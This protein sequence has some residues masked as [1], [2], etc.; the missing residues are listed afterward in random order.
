MKYN[1]QKLFESY[2]KKYHYYIE[3]AQRRSKLPFIES[4]W[5]TASSNQIITDSKLIK[6]DVGRN[7]VSLPDGC[8]AILRNISVT[9]FGLNKNDRIYPK[10]LWLKIVKDGVA[11][12]TLCLADHPEDE[13]S[14][15]MIV[16][17]WHNFRVLDDV[18]VADLYLTKK[19]GEGLLDVLKIDGRIGVSS[20]GYGE[21]GDDGQTVEV[22][23]YELVR[24]GDAVL[25]PSQEVF[26]TKENISDGNPVIPVQESKN[27][28]NTENLQLQS[29][30]SPT[31]NTNNS[32]TLKENSMSDLITE[33]HFKNTIKL[34]LKEAKKGSNLVETQ[35]ELQDLYNDIPATM[36]DLKE[37]INSEL[38][39]ITTKLEE[40][41]SSKEKMV[42][43]IGL[44][45]T[46]LQEKHSVATR[47]LDV[48][49]EKYVDM[50]SNYSTLE[51]SNLKMQED[52]GRLLKDREGMEIDV[53]N[54]KEAIKN[55]KS[56][57]DKSSSSTKANLEKLL[58]ERKT[59][60][61]D[62]KRLIEERKTSVKDSNKMLKERASMLGEIT[63][64]IKE[65]K[66]MKLNIVK[67]LTE[68]KKMLEDIRAFL[69]ER[70]NMKSDISNLLHENASLKKG[71]KLSEDYDG[72]VDH[73]N[74]AATGD[75]TEG[76]EAEFATGGEATAMQRST[77]DPNEDNLGDIT[78]PTLTDAQRVLDENAADV[79][80]IMNEM[81]GDTSPYEVQDSQEYLADDPSLN[82]AADDDAPGADIE[83][84]YAE[85]NSS[86]K[87][88]VSFFEREVRQTP[89]LKAIGKSVLNSK[90]LVE[91]VK[92]VEAFKHKKDDQPMKISF[93][94]KAAKKNAGSWLGGRA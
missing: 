84:Q 57:G 20:V 86:K 2:P 78:E 13:G 54:L 16:G 40:D 65:R 51:K 45:K 59:L 1:Y 3:E 7:N 28:S 50:K 39:F 4:S 80:V 46:D 77:E 85:S 24:L 36:N 76:D 49:K 38:T 9:R 35:K 8:I 33:S 60:L 48:L 47:A 26:A 55:E 15:L 30:F 10:L 94:E 31:P 53:D 34:R 11:E 52:I 19:H 88:L 72:A 29:E 37:K 21:L 58:V 83:S 17:V 42:E 14:V 56:S 23:S 89:A 92:K 41:V 63:N 44:E 82:Y 64:L 79:D 93:K 81:D 87:E 6:E 61:V 43:Q 22:E 32:M 73:A 67:M 5:L 74:E 25:E 66:T 18:G 71:N 69:V 75:P 68:R 27:T 91:A 62:V 12:R 90:S 70:K